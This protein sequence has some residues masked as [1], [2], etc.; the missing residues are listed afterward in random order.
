M[1]ETTSSR[2]DAAARIVIEP[3]RRSGRAVIRD[4]RIAVA[5]VLSM[6]A[7]GMTVDAVLADFPEL[8][9]ADVMAALAHAAALE[10]MTH[11]T[12]SAA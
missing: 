4:T 10:G 1:T 3:G 11:E 12:G 2:Y 9:R 8:E 5:D 7:A 6:L